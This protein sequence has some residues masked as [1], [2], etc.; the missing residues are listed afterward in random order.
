MQPA[1]IKYWTYFKMNVMYSSH[2]ITEEHKFTRQADA[3]DPAYRMSWASH[4]WKLGLP[5]FPSSLDYLI[6][7]LL[8]PHP[9]DSSFNISSGHSLL[10]KPLVAHHWTKWKQGSLLLC[11]SLNWSHPIEQC[12]FPCVL[13]WPCHPLWLSSLSCEYLPVLQ[14]DAPIKPPSSALCLKQLFLPFTVYPDPSWSLA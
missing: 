1:V 13:L 2:R 5:S 14:A 4:P 7:A 10:Q 3:L 9:A 11:F 12:H 6:L 8:S